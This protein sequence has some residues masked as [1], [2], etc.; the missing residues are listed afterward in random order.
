MDNHIH[1]GLLVARKEIAKNAW[2]ITFRLESQ[3]FT[4]L[5]GQYIWVI[6][7]RLT[8]QDPR[9]SRRPFSIASPPNTTG[10][11]KIITRK[12]ESGY[13]RTLS[14]LPLGSAVR[15]RGPHGSSF[16]CERSKRK[17]ISYAF[18]AGGIGI[19]PFLSILRDEKIFCGT[20]G[21][22]ALLYAN[23]IPEQAIAL[24]DLHDLQ[25][26]YADF[27][28]QTV[29]G[30]LPE[31]ALHQIKTNIPQETHWFVCGSQSFVNVVYTFLCKS[32]VPDTHIHFEEFYPNYTREHRDKIKKLNVSLKASDHATNIF[33]QAIDQLNQH[34]TIL[35]PNG[36]VVY[37]NKAAETMTG[38]SFEEM[39]GQTPRLW[40]GLMGKKFYQDLWKLKLQ[41]KAF[42]GEIINQRKN[43]RI[44]PIIGHFSPIVRQGMIIGFI[45]TEEDITHIKEVDRVKS[46]FVSLA[47]HQLL[48]PL[49]AI[50]WQTE[51]LRENTLGTLNAKQRACAQSIAEMGRRMA[52]L[53]QALLQAS[54]LELGTFVVEPKPVDVKTLLLDTLKEMK[55]HV[56]KKRLLITTEIHEIPPDLPA[57]P[58][59]L[60]I[61]FL[62]LISNAIK[63]TPDTKTI[64]L[65]LERNKNKITFSVKDQ[66]CGIPKDQQKNIFTKLF[67]A[68][69]AKRLD[70]NGTGLGLY[71]VKGIAEA[72]GGDISF[73]SEE[74][75]GST[76]TFTF[77]VSGMKTKKKETS[78]G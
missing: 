71:I 5:P 15:V 56:E 60:H 49:T 25:R 35:D 51:L 10:E 40:G 61:V 22:V 7:P 37:A 3:E 67:R 8:H 44:Y 72:S 47:A 28:F 17:A 43:E 63:Y 34:V 65:T 58:N 12:S 70:A 18:I 2:E 59:L 9:G 6:L 54:R 29:T 75:V 4:F 27:L 32:S 77:P 26:R 62:N 50:L 19:A 78:P 55:N 21:K 30:K 42:H 73:F 66:G 76:F 11:I 53:V 20:R 1:H 57:D 52:D 64:I 16:V 14:D 13:H 36:H 33:K 45:A 74:D 24:D 31:Y 39:C 46:E 68:E 48:S 38:F 69:N 41:G 23:Q